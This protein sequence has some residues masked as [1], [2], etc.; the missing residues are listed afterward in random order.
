MLD[1]ASSAGSRQDVRDG[2]DG[3]TRVNIAIGR[4]LCAEDIRGEIAAVGDDGVEALRAELLDEVAKLQHYTD[5]ATWN[6]LVRVCDA[7]ALVGWGNGEPREA[8]AERW[9]NSAMYTYQRGVDFK[10]LDRPERWI[11]RGAGLVPDGHPDAEPVE[12]LR[13]QEIPLPKNPVRIAYPSLNVAE[14]A[15]AFIRAS[16]ELRLRLDRKLARSYGQGFGWIGFELVSSCAD[17]HLLN[18]VAGEPPFV[19]Y[20]SEFFHR[21]ADVVRQVGVDAFVRPRL[22]IGRISKRRGERCLVVTRHYTSAEQTE[23]LATRCAGLIDDLDA[24]LTTLEAKLARSAPDYRLA[25][26]RRDLH[27]V[28]DEWMNPGTADGGPPYQGNRP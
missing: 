26:L 6:R 11:Q 27:A 8:I 20:R 7:L 16:E 13:S 12:R 19:R 22:E 10:P 14:D 15:V 25:E 24:V 28:A 3:A 2:G 1:V 23:S 21:D 17:G 18:E 5:G 4:L 9:L